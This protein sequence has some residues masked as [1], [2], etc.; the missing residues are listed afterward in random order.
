LPHRARP[1][2]IA[3]TIEEQFY[4]IGKHATTSASERRLQD[5]RIIARACDVWWNGGALPISARA[6]AE[7]PASRRGALRHRTCAASIPRKFTPT[8]RGRCA[9]RF[10]CAAMVWAYESHT[11]L[12]A[13]ELGIVSDRNPPQEHPARWSNRMPPARSWKDAGDRQVLIISPRD[14]LERAVRSRNGGSTRARYRIGQS[15]ISPTTSGAIVECQ[16]RWQYRVYTNTNRHGAG[17]G[18]GM[19]RSWPRAERPPR[20]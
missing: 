10:R 19:R 9:A 11:D 2:K 1:V 18:T 5:G 4:T 13:R 16:R 6:C 15:V 7:S 20:A 8:A 12:I 14:E 3:L 17:L